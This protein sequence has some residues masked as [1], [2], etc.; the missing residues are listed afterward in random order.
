MSLLS[1]VLVALLLP[2]NS[3]RD[4]FLLLPQKEY[5]SFPSTCL[6]IREQSSQPAAAGDEHGPVFRLLHRSVGCRDPA[7]RR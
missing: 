5:R 1:K 3:D 7:D 6:L 4:K 2:I